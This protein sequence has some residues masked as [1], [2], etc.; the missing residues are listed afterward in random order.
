MNQADSRRA[1]ERTGW[2]GRHGAIWVI[3]LALGLPG[4]LVGCGGSDGDSI[5]EARERDDR[6]TDETQ[7]PEEE[8]ESTTTL[9]STTTTAAPRIVYEIDGTGTVLVNYSA[10]GNPMQNR[11]VTLPWSEEQAEEPS[12]LSMLVALTGSQGDVTCRIRRG[13]EVLAEATQPADAGPL[14]SCDHPPG[15]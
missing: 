7:R 2:I 6:P 13:T 4:V 14:L 3:V 1:A 9:P 12:R 15:P 11:Q 5:A 10:A 8:E